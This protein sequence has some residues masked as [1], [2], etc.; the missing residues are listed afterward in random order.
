MK[1]KIPWKEFAVALPLAVILA[2]LAIFFVPM[3]VLRMSPEFDLKLLKEASNKAAFEGHPFSR[4]DVQKALKTSRLDPS[5]DRGLTVQV[6]G[7]GL[8]WT[9]VVSKN[10]LPAFIDYFFYRPDPCDN[11]MCMISSRDSNLISVSATQKTEIT[12]LNQ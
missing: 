2:Q 3:C 11:V 4:D 8:D 9:V 7:S 6:L 1:W 10:R 12:A 5:K